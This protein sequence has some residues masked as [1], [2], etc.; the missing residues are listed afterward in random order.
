MIA[1]KL[2]LPML[3]TLALSACVQVLP[4]SLKE[5]MPM[6]MSAGTYRPHTL[7]E[8][9]DFTPAELG[10]RMLKLIDSLTSFDELSLARV[11]EVMR[12]PMHE[13]DPNRYG[14]GMHLPASDWYCYISYSDTPCIRN[15]RSSAINSLTRMRP[16]T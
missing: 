4:I 12:M 15:P 13:T 16:Q 2:L 8:Y 9:P 7:D 11:Q 5:T 1:H 10:R 14:F 3:A 6:T